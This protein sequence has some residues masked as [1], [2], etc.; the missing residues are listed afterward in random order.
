MLAVLFS[1]EKLLGFVRQILI[2]RQFQLSPELDAFN[3]ANNLPDLLFA[4]ISAG[5]I[6]MAFIPVLSEAL[7][8]D[9][10]PA[11]WKLFSQIANLFFPILIGVSILIAIFADQ[12]VSWRLGVAPG[13][14]AS[15]RALVADLM[16]IN[17]LATLIFSMAGF[18]IAGAQANQHFF[19]PAL[20]PIFYDLGMLIGVLVL[21]P[22]EPYTFG[23][24]TLP[25]LGLGIHGLVYGTV[26]GA[27]LYFGIQIP[28]L[29]ITRFRWFPSLSLREPR[30]QRVL[31][32]VVPRL[33]TVLGINLVFLLQDNL[34]SRLPTGSV[35]ALVFGWLILQVP[36]TLIGT[37]LGTALLPTLSEQSARES[38][39]PS[40]SSTDSSPLPSTESSTLTTDGSENL[41]PSA[42]IL[43]TYKSTISH[44]LRVV[45]ALTIPLIALISPILEPVVGI[46]GFDNSGTQLVVWTARA[47][48]LGLLGHSLLEI[49]VRSYYARQ[50]AWIPLAGAGVL[51]L[52]MLIFAIPLAFWLG[53]PGIALAN[54]LAFTTQA[55]FLLVFLNWQLGRFIRLG[56]TP[57]RS[58][59]AALAGGLACWLAFTLSTSFLSG[60][61]LLG[62]NLGGILLAGLSALLGAA[63]AAPFIWP[64]LKLFMRL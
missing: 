7:E 57:W 40:S 22:T 36:E 33:F 30:V 56:R 55:V 24:I 43:H 23:P 46:L 52:S 6:G 63:A 11:L 14:T 50:N 25:A 31:L 2:A 10:R 16:R 53:A 15:Q 38:D 42:F 17:L 64:E 39:T 37:S 28:G 60:L 49:A 32:L 26:L 54:T 13:F 51:T 1:I 19:F 59:L 12:L 21:S 3:A 35:T 29:V 4:L 34:A 41:H 8:K 47:F 20:A 58:L 48:L 9:G 44:S 18:A 61:P 62:S 45:I 5:A 27:L